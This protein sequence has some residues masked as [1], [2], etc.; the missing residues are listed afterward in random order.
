MDDLYQSYAPGWGFTLNV[1]A[2]LGSVAVRVQSR[3]G[4]RS[5]NALLYKIGTFQP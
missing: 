4:H 5:Y 2:R 1:E 3:R